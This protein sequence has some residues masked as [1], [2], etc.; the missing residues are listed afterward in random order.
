MEYNTSRSTLAFPEYGRNVQLLVDYAVSLKDESDREKSV[1][2]IIAVMGNLKPQLRD[3]PDFKHLL[4]DHLAIMSD[5]QLAKYSPYPIPDKDNLHSKPSPI[6]RY[7][8]DMKYPVFGRIVEKL[9]EKCKN[10]S[11]PVRRNE[12]IRTIT[13]HMKKSYVLWNKENINDEVVFKVLKEISGGELQVTD[14]DLKLIDGKEFMKAKT[15]NSNQN[16]Q[17]FQSRNNSSRGNS[18]NHSNNNN[19]NRRYFQN[20]GLHKNN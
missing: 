10:I 11:N 7:E 5:F 8:N 12:M 4:W 17:G 13:N 6:E 3:N 15:R 1:K 19:N 18:Q 2:A 16:N 9:M 20:N 14:D